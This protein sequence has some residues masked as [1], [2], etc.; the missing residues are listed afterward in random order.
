M[1]LSVEQMKTILDMYAVV[2]IEG[3]VT[4][5][6]TMLMCEVAFALD[7]NGVTVCDECF[8]LIEIPSLQN[9]KVLPGGDT[10]QFCDL[11]IKE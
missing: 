1:Q 2:R 6:I 4:D 7:Q 5:E 11:C 8:D 10:M 9:V 3:Q